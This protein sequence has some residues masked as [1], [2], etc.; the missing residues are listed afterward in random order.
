MRKTI[1]PKEVEIKMNTETIRLPTNAYVILDYLRENGPK[2]QKALDNELSFSLRALRYA[3]E[4]LE[5][6]GLVEKRANLVDMR[7]LYLCLTALGKEVIEGSS[8]ALSA[9]LGSQE[10]ETV[11][12]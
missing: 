1:P 6:G 5:R 4:R 8:P 3:L 10:D 2:T 11:P 9:L 12:A 7:S